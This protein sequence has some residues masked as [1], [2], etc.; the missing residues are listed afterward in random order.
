M[1]KSKFENEIFILNI[2]LT[3]NNI[4]ELSFFDKKKDKEYF[5]SITDENIMEYVYSNIPSFTTTENLYPIKSLYIFSKNCIESKY[6]Y[7]LEVNNEK[8]ETI[9]LRFIYDIE[10]CELFFLIKEIPEKK[11]MIEIEKKVMIM[12]NQ[13]KNI[14]TQLN[15]LE[16][17]MNEI[18]MNNIDVK[19]MN[20]NIKIIK[21]KKI[22]NEENEKYVNDVLNLNECNKNIC[23]NLSVSS[24]EDSNLFNFLKIKTRTKVN[25][26]SGIIKK[27]SFIEKFGKA[28]EI[29]PYKNNKHIESYLNDK[30]EYI[31]CVIN[32]EYLNIF[33]T[34]NGLILIFHSYYNMCPEKSLQ[35][36]YDFNKEIKNDSYRMIADFFDKKIDVDKEML[37]KGNMGIIS[38][39]TKV[40]KFIDMIKNELHTILFK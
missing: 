29:S 33:M 2:F 10:I 1:E 11:T 28:I 17:K 30:N 26:E 8:E 27:K 21:S 4:L 36:I 20:E 25:K 39:F 9:S 19:K 16:T 40:D 7:F 15:M 35:S 13:I 23:S 12:D 6:N 38:Y 14:Q 22:E 5:L 37:N 18:M 3:G 24:D 31:Q 34:N 32:R